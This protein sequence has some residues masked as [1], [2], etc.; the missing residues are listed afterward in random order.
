MSGG[1]TVRE[2]YAVIEDQGAKKKKTVAKNN[3]TR[4]QKQFANCRKGNVAKCILHFFL[5]NGISD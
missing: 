3:C 4:R 5:G 2:V 1:W